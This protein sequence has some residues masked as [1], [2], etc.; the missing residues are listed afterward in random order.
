MFKEIKHNT[1]EHISENLLYHPA[2]VMVKTTSGYK[3]LP[4]Y[5]RESNG[6]VYAKNGQFYIALMKQS[7]TSNSKITWVE[8][9]GLDEVYEKCYLVYKSDKGDAVKE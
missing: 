7:I 3:V 6:H 4:L 8:L 2:E 9:D 1:K 5:V